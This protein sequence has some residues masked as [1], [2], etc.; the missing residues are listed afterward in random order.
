MARL[1]IVDDSRFMRTCL[2]E[3][4]RET[5]LGHAY[6]AA[7]GVEAIEQYQAFGPEL[8]T[9]D[10]TMPVMDGLEALR[11]LRALH[12][13]ARVLMI[14]SMGQQSLVREALAYGAVGF[15]VK[16]FEPSSVLAE[17]TRALST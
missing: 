7:N 3:I 2:K 6:E 10:I 8:V 14:S 17:I 12:A 11:T 9:M 15:V 4:W 1:L 5:G 16:P 13:D